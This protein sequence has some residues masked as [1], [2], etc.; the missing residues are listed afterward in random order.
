MSPETQEDVKPFRS[1]VQQLLNKISRATEPQCVTY[2]KAVFT[3]EELQLI[4]RTIK[5]TVKA[6][7]GPSNA[8]RGTFALCPNG[9]S[10]Q[11]PQPGCAGN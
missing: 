2:D 3:G 7:I 10:L 11:L 1:E 9:V 6:L 4:E 8:Q 5:T